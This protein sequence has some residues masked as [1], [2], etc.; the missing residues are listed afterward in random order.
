MT[1]L[2]IVQADLCTVLFGVII[3]GSLIVVFLL[4][5]R[6]VLLP[7]VRVVSVEQIFSGAAFCRRSFASAA[8]SGLVCFAYLG[9]INGRE[10][11]AN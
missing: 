8:V 9:A 4:L 6:I 1:R 11:R 10:K 2:L 5:V 7:V 3:G